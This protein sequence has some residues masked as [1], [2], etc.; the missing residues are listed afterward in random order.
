MFIYRKVYANRMGMKE[1]SE[2]PDVFLKGFKIENEI[3]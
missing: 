1:E 2:M 3:K